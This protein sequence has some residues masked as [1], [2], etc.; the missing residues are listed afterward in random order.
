M[1]TVAEQRAKAGKAFTEFTHIHCSSRFDRPAA[2][3]ESDMDDWMAVASL[4]TVTE[5]NNDQRA[6]TLREKGWGYY[7]AKHGDGADECGI[8]WRLD[9]WGRMAADV[10]KLTNQQ[11]FRLDGRVAEPIWCCSV[12][13]RRVDTG[14]RMLVSVTHMPAHVEGKGGWRTT[15]YKWQARKNAYLSSL[16]NWGQRI[17]AL[18]TQH[19]PDMIMVVAD[20]NLNLKQNWVRDLIRHNFTGFTQAWQRFPTTGGSLGGGPV[21]PLGAPGVDYADRIIDGTL[22]AGGAVTVEP[23][24]M[25]RVASSDHRPYREGLA[26]AHPAGHP[27]TPSDDGDAEGNTSAGDPWWG[28]GDYRVD[29]IYEVG[30]VTGSA[31]GEVL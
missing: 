29:E 28:F 22:I 31:G 1:A 23:N 14:H 7:N 2:Q 3:L 9:T 27:A 25:A 5:I 20:W 17:R 10:T 11:Y 24:L 8:A 21:A 15:E 12:V 6:G 4:V 30:V 16:Q 19:K 13:L 18:I 26:F